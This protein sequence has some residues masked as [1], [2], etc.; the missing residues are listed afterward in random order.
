MKCTTKMLMWMAAV[1]VS[2]SAF[3][4]SAP[5]QKKN[6]GLEAALSYKFSYAN[7]TTPK[8][9]WQNG[10]SV[11]LHGQ[12]WKGLG[13]VGRVDGLHTSDM[14]GTGV[15]LDLVTAT[16]GPRY[17]WTPK[18]SRFRYYGEVLGGVSN[19]LNSQFPTDSGMQT[20]ATSAA[21]LLGGGV[22][23]KL[24]KWLGIRVFDAHWMR[25]DF[26]NATTGNQNTLVAGSGIIFRLP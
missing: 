17:T 7:T 15:G 25:T 12:F 19:G 24:N 21:F 6:T 11:E 18:K 8:Q 9:F 26:P 4:Q 10:G 23:Y 14:Q 5:A 1:L 22:N 2:S 16:F 20:S 13:A 3:G